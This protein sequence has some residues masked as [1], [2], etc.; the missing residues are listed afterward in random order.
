MSEYRNE[1]IQAI[2]DFETGDRTNNTE[3]F[4]Y[5]F[6]P[7]WLS[8]FAPSFSYNANYSWN[9]PKSSVFTYLTTKYHPQNRPISILLRNTTKHRASFGL[10]FRAA[11]PGI[12]PW[13]TPGADLSPSMLQ[14]PK[15][16]PKC[17]QNERRGF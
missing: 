5:A 1:V 3:S 16:V 4:S 2:T 6:S 10:C 7:K 17:P 11:V 14:G 9:K 8:W 15:M 12:G 13:G